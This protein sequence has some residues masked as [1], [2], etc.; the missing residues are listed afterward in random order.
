MLGFQ[1]LTDLTGE[2]SMAAA[3]P[4]R[5]QQDA[6]E[7][8]PVPSAPTVSVVMPVY[9]GFDEVA[10]SIKSV[11]KQHD[12]KLE[13]LLID[14]GSTDGTLEILKR[15]AEDFPDVV[16]VF[17][18]QNAGPAAARNLGVQEARSQWIA[19]CDHDD[20][21]LPEKLSQQM[22]SAEQNKAELVITA[23]RNFGE[24]D[25]V[26]SIRHVPTS[27][28][29]QAPFQCLL[30]DN[31]FTLSTV[32]VRRDRLIEAGLFDEQWR[33][34]EDW[35]MWLNLVKAGIRIAAVEDS[36]VEYRWASSS[37]SRKHDAMQRQRRQLV[38]DQLDSDAG[39]QLPFTTRRKILASE[40]KTSAWAMSSTSMLQA[41][42][43]YCQALTAWPFDLYAWKCLAKCILRRPV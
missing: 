1:G 42:R 41:A 29:L 15:Y 9:N 39:R 27:A 21:W 8:M 37:L 13:L 19:F 43:C 11:L 35:A 17:Q 3:A 7:Q 30:F 40:R 26:D 23:C 22:I 5:N 24:I 33:G 36:L 31:R 20:L 2:T 4:I 6:S 16:R 34:V 12:V 28:E 10:D 14:D 25:R 38:V 32:L 18:Q